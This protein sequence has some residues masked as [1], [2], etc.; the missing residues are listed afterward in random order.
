[1]KIKSGGSPKSGRR[2]KKTTKLDG[3]SVKN[4]A[5]KIGKDTDTRVE[6]AKYRFKPDIA[7]E[8]NPKNVEEPTKYSIVYSGKKK[9]CN[10]N[11]VYIENRKWDQQ[12][13]VLIA[14]V[15]RGRRK[16]RGSSP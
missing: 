16:R 6:P 14:L 15:L 11:L 9:T 10:G 4:A 7:A 12:E 8:N 3:Q 1:M 2:F 13:N 5:A